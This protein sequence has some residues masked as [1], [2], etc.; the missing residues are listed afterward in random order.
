MPREGS[1]VTDAILHWY[2]VHSRPR[3]EDV[4]A[5]HLT[6]Q[7]YEVYLPRVK[8]PRHRR[9]RWLESVEPL[10]PRY[11]FAGLRP[12]Q[13]SLHPIRS[14]RGVAALVKSGEGYVPVAPALLAALRAEADAEGLH[15]LRAEGLAPGDRVRIVA[16]P[17]AGLEAVFHSHQGGERVRVLLQIIGAT[18]AALLPSNLLVAV[19]GGRSAVA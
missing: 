12:G 17:F 5:E 13:Q 19:H 9:A 18:T 1:F 8:L 15:R 6:R 14:T 3:Q 4:A 7:D 11:L 16:G 10:F 2:L